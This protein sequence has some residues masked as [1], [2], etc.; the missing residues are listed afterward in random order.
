MS[1]TATD[2]W[3]ELYSTVAS[4]CCDTHILD[5]N[6]VSAPLTAY[7]ALSWSISI[8]VFSV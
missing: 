4:P 1:S 6:G 5:P 3:V 2:A 8:L 7:L